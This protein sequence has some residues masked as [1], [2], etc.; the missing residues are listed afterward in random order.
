MPKDFSRDAD[1]FAF[2]D[3]STSLSKEEILNA[4]RRAAENSGTRGMSKVS[5]GHSDQSGTYFHF[6]ESGAREDSIVTCL[7]VRSAP[8]GSLV[9][10]NVVEVNPLSMSIMFI[11]VRKWLPCLSNLG[12]FSTALQEDL[13]AGRR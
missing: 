5:E 4:A 2:Q 6:K 13:R 3:F 12:K 9:D 7:A 1:G 10:L 11:P 8:E